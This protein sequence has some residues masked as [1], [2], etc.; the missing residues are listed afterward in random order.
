MRTA[1]IVAAMAAASGLAAC[2]RSPQNADG[3]TQSG[4]M[5]VAGATPDGAVADTGNDNAGA[6]IGGAGQLAEPGGAVDAG[7]ATSAKSE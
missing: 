5:G 2:D 7:G 6:D 4:D 3:T 1:L